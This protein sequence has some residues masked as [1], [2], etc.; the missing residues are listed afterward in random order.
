MAKRILIIKQL[1]NPEPTAKSLD[2]AKALVNEGFKVEVLTGYP[3]YPIGRIYDGY[4]Q[5]LWTKEYMY[6]IKVIRVP[7]YPQHS[8]KAFKR[9]LGYSSFAFAASMLGPFLCKKPDLIFA[10]QGAVTIGIPAQ[11]ISSLYNVPYVYDIN[12]L[13]PES[14]SASGILS[15]K[16]AISWIKKW[17]DFNLRKARHITVATDGF[18]NSIQ[19]QG[20]CEDKISVIS[21]WSRDQFSEDVLSVEAKNRLMDSDCF[22]ILYAGNLG[23]VQSLYSVL[24]GMMSLHKS[25]CKVNLILMG[26]G[27]ER[28]G[29]VDYVENNNIQNVTF[30]GRVSSKD[31]VK[32]LNSADALLVHLKKHTLFEI[33]IPSKILSYLRTSKPILCGLKGNAAELVEKANAGICFE[34]DNA[35]DFHSAV[36]NMIERLNSSDTFLFAG[37]SDYYNRNLSIE[38]AVEKFARLF[39]KL[40]KENGGY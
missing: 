16:F 10:Y 20:I 40:I 7:I 32:Y 31:V 28:K 22:N 3:N 26:D 39:N 36:L 6:G 33:T 12:D 14:V 38:I 34:P 9:V 5:K 27:A 37:G 17:S 4:K 13:W 21:N 15:N 2:F 1:W 35:Q 11:I 19:A 18:K 25:S 30:L 29:L 23:I 24:D 8:S